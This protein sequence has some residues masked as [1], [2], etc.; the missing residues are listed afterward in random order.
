M[1]N[2]SCA[3]LEVY[4]HRILVVLI[5]LFTKC[6]QALTNLR[7]PYALVNMMAAHT[8]F[9]YELVSETVRVVV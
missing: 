1:S 9:Q 5:V 3:V 8:A 6:L 7:S 4:R 2:N